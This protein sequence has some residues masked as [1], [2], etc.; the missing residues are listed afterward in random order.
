M[1]V[2]MGNLLFVFVRFD[3]LFTYIPV[4]VPSCLIHM[5]TLDSTRTIS[6]NDPENPY[7]NQYGGA[8]RMPA[9]SY[10]TAP[11][12]TRKQSQ[13]YTHRRTFQAILSIWQSYWFL[14]NGRQPKSIPVVKIYLLGARRPKQTNFCF[15]AFPAGG[16]WRGIFPIRKVAIKA[17]VIE[18]GGVESCDYLSRSVAKMTGLKLGL[19]WLVYTH[20]QIVRIA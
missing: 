17:R 10:G 20:T 3:L 2:R 13:I 5:C 19:F 14:Q 8:K 6:L 15:M 1:C 12:C 7:Y 9:S 16:W 4:F 18:K 11:T